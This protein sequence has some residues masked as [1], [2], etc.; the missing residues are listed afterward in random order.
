MGVFVLFFLRGLK[1][2]WVFGEEADNI[3]L[4]AEGSLSSRTVPWAEL[5]TCVWRLKWL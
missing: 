2:F 5:I 1:H 4:G 3:V